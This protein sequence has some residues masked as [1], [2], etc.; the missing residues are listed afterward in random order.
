MAH[1]YDKLIHMIDGSPVSQF[2]NSSPQ[3]LNSS[4]PQ[5][6]DPTSPPNSMHS[7]C[8]EVT[9]K[10]SQATTTLLETVIRR[11]AAVGLVICAGVL[12]P[13]IFIAMLCCAALDQGF[14]TPTHIVGDFI[15]KVWSGNAIAG[16]RVEYVNAEFN[17]TGHQI[18]NRLTPDDAVATLC[19]DP[20]DGS[21]PFIVRIATMGDESLQQKA[22]NFCK[23]LHSDERMKV[24]SCQDTDGN[25]FLHSILRNDSLTVRNN[26]SLLFED[27]ASCEKLD[28][29]FLIKNMYGNTIAHYAMFI[30]N[31]WVQ[32]NFL[33]TIL[34]KL[35]P[36]GARLEALTNLGGMGKTIL[37]L[38][39]ERGSE[40]TQLYFFTVFS[41]WKAKFPSACQE[42]QND[43]RPIQCGS[44]KDTFLHLALKSQYQAVRQAAVQFIT[45]NKINE[46]ILNLENS[47][48][49]T[50]LGLS[51]CGEVPMPERM[52]ER[53]DER[54]EF[55]GV[56]ERDEFDGHGPYARNKL[57]ADNL[58]ENEQKMRLTDAGEKY[59]DKLLGNL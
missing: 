53:V 57:V 58:E 48:C 49:E 8:D 10:E 56:D 29:L 18:L 38:A 4:T 19:K 27:I 40:N 47:K 46:D 32:Q 24:L 3:L 37:H 2:L 11:G 28:S 23:K 31:D 6:T 33:Y 26:A 59:E 50:V 39:M 25:T 20:G 5:L 43:I 35:R 9:A 21:G 22:I 34:G 14:Y 7:K 15:A 44:G 41:N 42:L 13:A 1:G 17:R 52:R 51:F 55:D 54:D 30:K 36:G 16:D 12:A 45:D